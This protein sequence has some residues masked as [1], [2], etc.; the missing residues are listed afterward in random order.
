MGLLKSIIGLIKLPFIILE[1]LL[2]LLFLPL[3]IL[4]AILPP[5][6]PSCPN[7]G[8]SNISK[9]SNGGARCADCGYSE[10]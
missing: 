6:G 8:S 3:D 5:Y 1:A 10:R 9:M 2:E 4:N 7:C